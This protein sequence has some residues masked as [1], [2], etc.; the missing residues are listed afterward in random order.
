MKRN[1]FP[2][3]EVMQSF[4]D[5]AKCSEHFV[6]LGFVHKRGHDSAKMYSPCLLCSG[7]KIN[8]SQ[9]LGSVSFSF[10]FLIVP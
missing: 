6:A 10:L 3:N 7:G 4:S 9:C 5:N 1:G 8:L 2:G